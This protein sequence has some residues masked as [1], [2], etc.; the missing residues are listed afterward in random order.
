MGLTTPSQSKRPG[1]R[2]FTKASTEAE[3]GVLGSVGRA[4]PVAVA[5]PV[6][7]QVA[8]DKKTRK[9]HVKNPVSFILSLM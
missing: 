9:K 2:A 6:Q 1:T 3:G 4:P 8:K 5:P 7:E